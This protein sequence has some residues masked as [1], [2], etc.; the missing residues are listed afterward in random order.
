MVDG[1]SLK[2]QIKKWPTEKDNN[3]NKKKSNYIAREI[4]K[5]TR[6]TEREIKTKQ[7]SEEQNFRKLKIE[8][9]VKAVKETE[10]RKKGRVLPVPL[11]NH[12]IL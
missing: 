4:N 1:K 12:N 3:S 11:R 10:K 5:I 7:K 6:S 9:V 2:T 8:L